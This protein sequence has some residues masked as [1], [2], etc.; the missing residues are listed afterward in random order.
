M[1]KYFIIAILGLFFCNSALAL[2]FGAPPVI[3]I[4]EKQAQEKQE[5]VTNLINQ[6]HKRLE[7]KHYCLSFNFVRKQGVIS[8]TLIYECTECKDQVQ[9]LPPNTIENKIADNKRI[10]ELEKLVLDFGNIRNE[11]NPQKPTTT[12]KPQ[13][14]KPG[15]PNYDPNKKWSGSEAD[16]QELAKIMKE[17]FS[18]EAWSHL[19]RDVASLKPYSLEEVIYELENG[20]LSSI[21]IETGDQYHQDDE[22]NTFLKDPAIME[23]I[24]FG[25]VAGAVAG[26][27]LCSLP[28]AL[29][30]GV[31]G[32]VAV[33]DKV[34]LIN[35][36]N[37][38]LKYL[39]EMKKKGIEN[40]K[41]TM[42]GGREAVYNLGTG[43]IVMNEKLG[44]Q[45]FG[46]RGVVSSVYGNHKKKDIDPNNT[47]A[48]AG[49]QFTRDGD[50]YKYVGILYERDKNDPNKFYIINGQTGE[51][52]TAKQAYEFAATISDMWVNENHKQ[53]VI[54][55]LRNP[56]VFGK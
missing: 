33:A 19:G 27:A 50:Q 9:I 8:E 40:V 26:G 31:A 29:F 39:N 36:P 4:D 42:S 28:C 1:K 44:T 37:S 2:S 15:S 35:D 56:Q 55:Q 43:K 25:G 7:E 46:E 54:D 41:I 47:K 32:A 6:N 16:L 22:T 14:N 13:S 52:M 51:K 34:T 23:E 38:A 21:A 11:L 3:P 45:N 49:N 48:I 18:D 17:K 10:M 30:G 5:A 12:S 20:S 24:F 53:S